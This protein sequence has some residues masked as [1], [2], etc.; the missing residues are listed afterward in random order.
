MLV[1]TESASVN[2]PL[3]LTGTSTWSRDARQG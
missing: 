3:L 2:R 1:K